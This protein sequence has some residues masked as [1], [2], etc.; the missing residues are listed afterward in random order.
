MHAVRDV[1]SN[2][3]LQR[4]AERPMLVSM[5]TAAGYCWAKTNLSPCWDERL[6]EQCLRLQ[7]G[8]CPS[9]IPDDIRF[10]R[11]SPRCVESTPPVA[12]SSF[13]RDE[14]RPFF[15]KILC[16]AKLMKDSPAFPR[17]GGT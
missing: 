8:S 5:S 12:C 16:N 17:N 10:L 6:D 4:Q 2:F 15:R 13:F 11:T 3:V 9:R 14:A 1:L 7:P